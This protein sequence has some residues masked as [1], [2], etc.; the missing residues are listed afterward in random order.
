MK[1]LGKSEQLKGE[2]TMTVEDALW[3]IHNVYT[4]LVQ[5]DSQKA[6]S[7]RIAITALSKQIGIPP[8]KIE[9][10]G[11]TSILCPQCNYPF[12]SLIEGETIAEDSSPYCKRCG[13]RI[14]WGKEKTDAEIH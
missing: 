3:H 10:K 14:D 2:K 8:R 9:G 13:Q 6:E 1:I 7:Y 11:V 5:K 12:Y 4:N